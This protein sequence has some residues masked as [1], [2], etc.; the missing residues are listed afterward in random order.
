[1]GTEVVSIATTESIFTDVKFAYY[2][3][4]ITGITTVPHVLNQNENIE[5]SG[6]SSSL[7]KNIEGFQ[8]VGITTVNTTVAVSIASSTL[9][10][11]I[12]LAGS[13]LSRKFEI[14]DEIQINAEKMLVIGID[15]VNN[16]YRVSRG[17][18]GTTPVSYTH[19]R[20]HETAS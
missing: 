8:K 11:N 13:T 7:Y 10:T 14:D 18:K 9:D 20:A 5:I 3:G 1:M 17:Y 12:H 2:D 19:L 6:I 4:T 16:R 15:D